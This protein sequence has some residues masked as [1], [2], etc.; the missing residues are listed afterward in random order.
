[1]ASR[2]EFAASLQLFFT[3]RPEEAESTRQRLSNWQLLNGSIRLQVRSGRGTTFRIELPLARQWSLR[4]RVRE[5]RAQLPSGMHNMR[6]RALFVLLFAARLARRLQYQAY[7]ARGSPVRERAAAG[8]SAAP[9]TAAHASGCG[10]PKRKKPPP[11]AA[12][13]E[14]PAPAPAKRPHRA[15]ARHNPKLPIRCRQAGATSDSATTLSQNLAAA[16]I[17]RGR[18]SR[19]PKTT[20]SLQAAS[21]LISVLLR[22]T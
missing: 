16:R 5:M 8:G 7:C 12:P 15:R 6:R 17:T 2:R 21:S 11:E 18:I 19:P 10:K 9:S 3:T 14:E 1:V 4:C 13:P 22:K 20:C